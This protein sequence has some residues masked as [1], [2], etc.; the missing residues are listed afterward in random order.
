MI[1]P[2]YQHYVKITIV[3]ERSR[4]INNRLQDDLTQVLTF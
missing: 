2:S 4:K 3:R 1:I